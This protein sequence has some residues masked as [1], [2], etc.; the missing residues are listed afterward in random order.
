MQTRVVRGDLIMYIPVK[1]TVQ[2]DDILRVRSP[3][4]GRVEII[5]ANA[6]TWYHPEDALGYMASAQLAAL[7]DSNHT[8]PEET[9]QEHW[10]S[11]FPLN[12]LRCPQDCFVLAIS[13][14]PKTWSHPGEVLF[15]VAQTL[16]LEGELLD[17]IPEGEHASGTFEMWPVSDPGQRVRVEIERLSPKRVSAL[18]PFGANFAPG[19]AW[20]GRLEVMIRHNVLKVPTSALLHFKGETYLPLKVIEGASLNHETEIKLGVREGD[21]ALILKPDSWAMEGAPRPLPPPQPQEKKRKPSAEPT[22]LSPEQDSGLYALP[23]KPAKEPTYDDG[24]EDQ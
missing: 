24:D 14:K 5:Q 13:A 7:M 18:L 11:V 6:E 19:T 16:R 9:L 1:G 12:P 21:E 3:I 20:E 22:P 15:R 8:T 17:E 4:D 23:D 10:K 2:A